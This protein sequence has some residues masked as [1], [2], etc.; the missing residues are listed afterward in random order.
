M[1]TE[2]ANQPP[3]KPLTALLPPGRIASSDRSELA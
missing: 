3:A 1:N 2:D